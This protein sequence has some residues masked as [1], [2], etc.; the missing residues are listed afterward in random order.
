MSILVEEA[1]ESLRNAIDSLAEALRYLSPTS[2]AHGDSRQAL[3]C[4]I[5]AATGV[6]R[7]TD[8]PKPLLDLVRGRVL[9]AVVDLPTDLLGVGGRGAEGRASFLLLEACEALLEAEETQLDAE[10]GAAPHESTPLPLES[11][12]IDR[13]AAITAMVDRQPE[14]AASILAS[15][16]LDSQLWSRLKAHWS[17]W[18]DSASPRERKRL[19]ACQDRAYLAQLEQER[20]PVTVD[21]YARLK[22]AATHG[23]QQVVLKELGLPEQ[24]AMRLERQWLSRMMDSAELRQRVQEAINRERSR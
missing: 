7:S 21:E 4:A 19:I 8:D 16:E 15:L 9:L 5:E 17:T 20:G 22:V 2:P 23:A 13:C 3:T 6:Q 10:E 18:I 24:G 12:S 14:H 11:Y 1:R